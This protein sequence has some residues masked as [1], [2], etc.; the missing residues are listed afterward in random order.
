MVLNSNM[1]QHCI[2]LTLLGSTMPHTR[3]KS[4]L[5]R[6]KKKCGQQMVPQAIENITMVYKVYTQ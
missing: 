2:I 4:I 5:G 3:K 6:D 1:W